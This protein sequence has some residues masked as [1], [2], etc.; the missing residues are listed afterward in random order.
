MPAGRK[1]IWLIAGAVAIALALWLGRIVLAP[2]VESTCSK[3]LELA[4]LAQEA[5][6]EADRAACERHYAH[7]R[8]RRGAIGW[9]EMSWCVRRA[10]TIPDAGRC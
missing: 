2:D 3:V 6:D 5:T 9:A 4:E 10:R 8:Q 7:E 1:P